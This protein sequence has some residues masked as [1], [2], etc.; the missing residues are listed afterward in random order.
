MQLEQELHLKLTLIEPKVHCIRLL[1][2]DLPSLVRG[3]RKKPS[4]GDTSTQL[5]EDWLQS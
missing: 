1:C 3:K 4:R 5:S 2:H